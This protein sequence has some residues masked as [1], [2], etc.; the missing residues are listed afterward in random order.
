MQVFLHQLDG[1]QTIVEIT[2]N[3]DFNNFV[4]QNELVNCRLICQG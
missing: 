2:E 1:S 4:S 3:T